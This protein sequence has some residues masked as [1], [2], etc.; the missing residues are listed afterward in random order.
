MRLALHPFTGASRV[1]KNTRGESLIVTIKVARVAKDDAF[2]AR[3]AQQCSQPTSLFVNGGCVDGLMHAQ[4]GTQAQRFK[5]AFGLFF[6]QKVDKSK[7]AVFP[8]VLFRNA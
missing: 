2:V 1:C 4:V 3:S 5:R 6:G 7:S 8:V